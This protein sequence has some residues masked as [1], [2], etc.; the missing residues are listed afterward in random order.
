MDILH[1]VLLGV[2]EGITEFL[3]ISSTAH[4]I[5]A[6]KAFGIP[7]TEFLKSFEIVIQLGAILAVL[8]LYYKSFLNIEVLKRVVAGFI[9]TAILGLVFYKIVK[10][11]LGD[12]SV[13]LWALLVGGV[14][15]IIFEKYQKE[16]GEGKKDVSIK[17]AVK[18]GCFQ[19]LAFIPGTS[20]SAATIIGGLW[21]GISRTTIAEYSFLLAV[22]TMAAATGLDII[23]NREVLVQG[24][25]FPALVVGF[26]VAYVIA[27]AAIKLFISYVK[28]HD[29]VPFGVYR[30][31]LAFVG[32]AFLI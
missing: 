12:V 25:N 23:K 7:E 5:L 24:G 27:L 28:K 21:L 18:I 30:I 3:P 6:A 17:D 22:P 16:K 2:V 19:V 11:L 15:M 20:R 4:M 14:I 13:V 9:P 29:F 32:F 8:T 10:S 31:L 1:A 26:V